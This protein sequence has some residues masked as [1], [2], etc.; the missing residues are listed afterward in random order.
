[1][2]LQEAKASRIG[3]T[4]SKPETAELIRQYLLSHLRVKVT[5]DFTFDPTVG[6]KVT[7]LLDDQVIDEDWTALTHSHGDWREER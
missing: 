1:M 2:T 5:Q 6:V 4:M 3:G 7:L